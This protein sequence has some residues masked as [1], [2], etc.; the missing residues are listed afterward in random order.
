M[1]VETTIEQ[2]RRQREAWVRAAPM[3]DGFERM[4][5]E[6]EPDPDKQR[7]YRLTILHGRMINETRIRWCDEALEMLESDLSKTKGES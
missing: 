4:L 6:G 3:F 2:I 5:E 7:F 1:P